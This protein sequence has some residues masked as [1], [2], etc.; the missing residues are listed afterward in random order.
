MNSKFDNRIND[1]YQTLIETSDDD[2]VR[3]TA[4]KVGDDLA[5]DYDSQG[6]IKKT[7]RSA[8]GKDE[9]DLKKKVS[10]KRRE[11]NKAVK[12][13]IIPGIEKEIEAINKYGQSLKTR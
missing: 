2:K 12:K 1:I 8:T 11:R 6:F 7:I 4:K 10:F 9:Q 13:V 5:D 3:S